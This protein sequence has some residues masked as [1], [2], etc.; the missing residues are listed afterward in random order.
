MNWKDYAPPRQA[1]LAA[2]GPEPLIADRTFQKY[3]RGELG[4]QA[5][6]CQKAEWGVVTDDKEVVVPAGFEPAT[7]RV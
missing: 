1:D 3:Q 2:T 4:R 6:N 7:F 5:A